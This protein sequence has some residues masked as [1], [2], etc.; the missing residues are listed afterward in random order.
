MS[1]AIIKLSYIFTWVGGPYTAKTVRRQS[2][3]SPR[4]QFARQTGQGDTDEYMA[5]NGARRGQRS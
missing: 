2:Q 5:K 1:P 4:V 3:A